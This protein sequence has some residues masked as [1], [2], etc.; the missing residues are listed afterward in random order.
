MLK[1]AEIIMYGTWL[2]DTIQCKI[3]ILKWHT[4]YGSGDYED[5]PEIRDDR[6]VECYYVEVESPSNRGHYSS[7]IGGFLR[8]KDAISES[9]KIISQKIIWN[10]V[11]SR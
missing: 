6:E 2:Y 5:E 4:L 7:A 9:E 3:R 10:K 11:M 1:D 8:I